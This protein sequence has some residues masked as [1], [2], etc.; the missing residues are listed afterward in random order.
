[1]AGEELGASGRDDSV[2]CGAGPIACQSG[3]QGSVPGTQ[4]W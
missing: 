4:Q 3:M 1:M 2:W